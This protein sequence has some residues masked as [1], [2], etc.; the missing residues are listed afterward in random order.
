MPESQLIG[1]EYTRSGTMAGY[2]FEGR[3]K[4]DSTGAFVLRSMKEDYG[5]LFEKTIGQ[6]E[7]DHFRQI[8]QEE[9]MYKYK[10][11]YNPK[12]EVLDGW[13][14]GL[15][16]TFAD[17]TRFSSHGNNASPKGNGLR[18]IKEYMLELVEDGEMLK[19]LPE[20]E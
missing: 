12:F 18:R 7:M 11:S 17:G 8:I 3:V 13:S 4:A 1:I 16:I 20:E 2:A 14:W 5:P 19:D 15:W 6:V 9:E 10:E